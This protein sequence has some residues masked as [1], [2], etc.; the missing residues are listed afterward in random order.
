MLT[1]SDMANGKQKHKDK[2]C[3]DQQTSHRPACKT[4]AQNPEI[5]LMCASL[6]LALTVQA[7]VIVLPVCAHG[8]L[9]TYKH[10]FSHAHLH[11][12]C[13]LQGSTH[14]E[15]LLWTNRWGVQIHTEWVITAP[16][17]TSLNSK[18]NKGL[19]AISVIY[20]Q[21]C[22]P[23]WLGD[24]GCS[25]LFLSPPKDWKQATKK[26]DTTWSS[27]GNENAI[28]YSYCSLATI[29][30]LAHKNNLGILFYYQQ[31]VCVMKH[32]TDCLGKPRKHHVFF[33]E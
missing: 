28:S 33:C 6:P 7:A 3:P 10:H 16:L 32:F 18:C 30:W 19:V 31:R 17:S 11:Q 27:I 9:F 22:L 23:Q 1:A 20:S 14:T 15:Q 8:V 26:C 5:H 24:A 13:S 29:E 12:S 25:L 4:G 2:Q 21:L